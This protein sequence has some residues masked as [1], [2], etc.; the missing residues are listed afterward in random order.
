MTA[1][2]R[3]LVLGALTAIVAVGAPVASSRAAASAADFDCVQP[4]ATATLA[5]FEATT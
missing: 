4:S 5:P 2:K 3:G 1:R